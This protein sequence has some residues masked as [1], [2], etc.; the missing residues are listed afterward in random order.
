MTRHITIALL[1]MGPLGIWACGSSTTAPGTP[2][3]TYPLAV[4]TRWDYGAGLA[5]SVTRSVVLGGHEYSEIQGDLLSGLFRMNDRNQ[6][7]IRADE[8]DPLESILFDFGVP[9]GSSWQFAVKPELPAPTVTLL[10]KNDVVTV[11]AGTYTGCYTFFFDIPD[12]VDEDVTYVV[13]PDVGL[14]YLLQHSGNAFSLA[15]FHSPS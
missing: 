8:A 4:G 10:S 13:A 12:Q 11:P 2:P 3:L 15:G 7:L 9:V 14:V 6:L 1:L 5:D